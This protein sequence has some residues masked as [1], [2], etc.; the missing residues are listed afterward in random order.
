M[1]QQ[2]IDV[3]KERV[4]NLIGEEFKVDFTARNGGITTGYVMQSEF[5]I[6]ITV[7]G[8]SGWAGDNPGKDVELRCVNKSFVGGYMD[9]EEYT[10]EMYLEDLQSIVDAVDKGIIF[11]PEEKPVNAG[12]QGKMSCAFKK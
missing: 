2:E 12:M 8:K 10:Y 11:A 3:L 1:N 7:M 5:D 4:N 9:G 6:G